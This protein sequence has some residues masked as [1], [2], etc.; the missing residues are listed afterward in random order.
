VK[1]IADK[2]QS[3]INAIVVRRGKPARFSGRA[4]AMS[5]KSAKISWKAGRFSVWQT[6]EA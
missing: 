4:I 6:T 5:A 1:N 2:L 3:R